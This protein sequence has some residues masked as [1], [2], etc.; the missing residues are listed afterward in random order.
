MHGLIMIFG[1][2]MPAFVTLP[3]WM[4]AM[5]GGAADMAFARVNWH[6]E[7]YIVIFGAYGLEWTVPSP[8]PFLPS[9]PRR[10]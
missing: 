10:S 1:T 7:V 5:Q 6:P 3:N 2:I 8:A 9:R 4:I